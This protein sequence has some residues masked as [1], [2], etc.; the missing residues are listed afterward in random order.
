MQIL[1]C[2]LLKAV[3]TAI[4]QGCMTGASAA[5]VQ[6]SPGCCQVQL[7]TY[8][9]GPRGDSRCT[10]G[11][12]MLSGPDTRGISSPPLHVQPDCPT[13]RCC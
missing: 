1:P 3:P 6:S 9:T 12:G 10:K 13:P 5:T 7:Y 4:A 8:N 11:G 2:K